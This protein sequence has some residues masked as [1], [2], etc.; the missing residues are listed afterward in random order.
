MTA[1]L[2]IGDIHERMAQLED[3]S[4]DLIITSPPFL[5]LRSYLPDDH[6]QKHL[7]IGSEGTPAAYLDGGTS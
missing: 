5:A 4:F 6:P 1:T 3:H 7:E 2:L